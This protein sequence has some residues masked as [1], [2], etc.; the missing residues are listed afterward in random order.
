MTDKINSEEIS[1]RVSTAGEDTDA[2]VMFTQPNRDRPKEHKFLPD[3]R[4]SNAITI[5]THIPLP[6]SEDPIDFI[7]AR[8]LCSN[9]DLTD[10]NYNIRIDAVSEKHT[11]CLC[12]LGHYRS[13]IMQQGDRN[14]VMECLRWDL[15]LVHACDSVGSR[16]TVGWS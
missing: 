13:R 14:A 11:T 16:A 6:N 15:F 4:Q 7:T 3:H 9:I 10:G 12:D 8:L 5:Q 1:A 2:V